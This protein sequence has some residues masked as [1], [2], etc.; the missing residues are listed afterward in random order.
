MLEEGEKLED[1][2]DPA[3]YDQVLF[4]YDVQT[5]CETDEFDNLD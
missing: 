4:L 2:A 3:D 1:F 5:F